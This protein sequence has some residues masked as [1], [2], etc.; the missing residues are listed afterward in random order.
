ML[1]GASER[2]LGRKVVSGEKAGLREPMCRWGTPGRASEEHRPAMT[3]GLG[4]VRGQALC[5]G[6]AATALLTV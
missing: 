1:E 6:D 2:G 4:G 5:V 3:S